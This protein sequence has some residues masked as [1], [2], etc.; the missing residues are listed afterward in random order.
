[1]LDAVTLDQLRTFIAAA[2]TGSFSAAGR[3][4]GRAQSV[5]SHTL[6]NLEAQLGVQLFDRTSR[7]PTLTVIGR[8]LL[9]D[10]RVVA[11]DMDLFKARA[12]GL[13]GGL[14]PELSVV[15]H[16]FLP[17]DV[18][19]QAV[20]AFHGMFPRTPLRISVEG[21][22][23]VIEPVLEG[24]SSFGIRA[25]LLTN[26]PDLTS[27]HLMT[28]PYLMVA[29][30]QHPLALHQGPIPARELARH[31]QLVLSDRSQL[32]G[33]TDLGVLS[34]ATWRLSDL[35]AKH[36]FLKAGLGWGGMPL[37]VVQA[38]V[39]SGAL[40]PLEFEETRANASI[41]LAAIYRTDT[42]P[43]PAGRWLLD[44]LKAVAGREKSARHSP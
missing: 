35:G 44:Q 25:P 34:P 17:T 1:M 23:A 27:E 36:A 30:P 40:V 37:H 32:T 3:K 28:V 26:H 5:V 41:S 8:E 12:K 31:V 6:G 19:T 43:G 18:L 2:E 22:G 42:P 16:V 7:S 14:E 13:A 29:S 24:Q 9:A 10:A 39:D 21:M 15:V 33:K 11:S 20:S 38:D 4:L